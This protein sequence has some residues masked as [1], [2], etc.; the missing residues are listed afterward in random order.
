MNCETVR[1]LL[2]EADLARLGG[3]CDTPL[4]LHLSACAS[5]SVFAELLNAGQRALR[6]EAPPRH[7]ADAVADA[8]L[9][10]ASGGTRAS[11][12]GRRVPW[13]LAAPAAAAAMVVLLLA[14]PGAGPPAKPDIRGTSAG[15]PAAPVVEIPTGR[16]AAIFTTENPRITVVWLYKENAR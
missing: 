16:S 15:T 9:R 5:C 3:R 13:A 10:L 8:V 2:L 14:R 1:E 7:D 6:T 12:R 4:A 11:R